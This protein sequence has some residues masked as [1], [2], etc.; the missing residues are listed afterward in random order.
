LL[1]NHHEADEFAI[2]LDDKET[3]DSNSRQ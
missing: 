3:Q 1:T 2:E